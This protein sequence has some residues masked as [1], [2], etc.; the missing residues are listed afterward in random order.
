MQ[1]YNTKIEL[2]LIAAC[3]HPSEIACSTI[4]IATVYM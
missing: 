2:K 4:T 3:I 1:Y